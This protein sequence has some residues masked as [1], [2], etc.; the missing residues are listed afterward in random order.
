MKQILLIEL[1]ENKFLGKE[2]LQE[3]QTKTKIN[4]NLQKT[5]IVLTPTNTSG[6]SCADDTQ[7]P[8]GIHSSILKPYM[9]L[10]CIVINL[11][12]DTYKM[13]TN[14]MWRLH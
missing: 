8:V 1:R 6:I 2:L 3:I 14:K 4:I 7:T 9:W 12:K 5:I 10:I 13:W 11:K